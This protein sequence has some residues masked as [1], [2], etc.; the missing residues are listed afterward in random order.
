MQLVIA[1]KP[2][3]G[4]SIAK[5]LKANEKKDGYVQ[6]NGF[7]VSW[8]IGHLVTLANAEDYDPSYKI[9]KRDDLP[10][11]PKEWKYVV[12]NQTHK[13]F[14][15][16]EEL[17]HRSNIS[18]VICAT[19]AGREGELIFRLVY[20]QAKCSKP[21][22]RLWLS[23][24]EDKAIMKAFTDLRPGKDFDNLYEAAQCRQKADWIVGISGTRLFSSVYGRNLPVGRVMTPTLAIIQE[25]TD[26]IENF[27]VEKFFT[28]I[29]NTGFESV[30]RRMQSLEE[31]EKV[32]SKCQG[33]SAT[34][35]EMIA[36]EKKSMP[37]KLFDLTTLQRVCNRYFGYT[38]QQV[39][40]TAQQLYEKK[41][42]TY[43]RTD[44]CYVSEDTVPTVIGVLNRIKNLNLTE[45]PS[46][47]FDGSYQDNIIRFV[48]GS[49]VSDH[50]ALLPTEQIEK[51]TMSQLTEKEQ[52][53][54]MCVI[55]RLLC[56]VSP[57]EIHIERR[58]TLECEGEVFVAKG[59][60]TKNEGWKS[61][62]RAYQNSIGKGR[63]NNED[64]DDGFA[65]ELPDLEKGTKLSQMKRPDIKAGET[66]PP[67]PFTE[68]TL[69]SAM[70]NASAKDFAAIEGV[71]RTGLGTPATRAGVIEKLVKLEFITRK[72]K[73]LLITQKGRSLISIVPDQI[74]SAELTVG[75]EKI[76]KEIEKGEVSPDIFM[77]AIS[78]SMRSIVSNYRK[79]DL[80]ESAFESKEIIGSCPR[81][82]S[83]VIVHQKGFFCRNADCAFKL[84][85]NDMF[86]SSRKKEITKTMAVSFLKNRK[87]IVK[88]L[89]SEKKGKEYDAV[90]LM[91]DDGGDRVHFR[92]SFDDPMLK[93]LKMIDAKRKK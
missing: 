40:D 32:Q 48:D 28:V 10:I 22:R 50:H 25:R 65:Q 87:A 7:I 74:K 72:G 17:M 13:Q 70:E 66:T 63:K 42:L 27:N 11:I 36:D 92:L 4:I 69:L 41:L 49:K 52:N 61:V 80:S 53:V 60:T 88:G 43:P 67:K 26:A 54:L 78:L 20:M 31:A 71:E 83:P 91:E 14:D 64:K 38:A 2:S 47:Y 57:E 82:G 37:P 75:W 59:K 68:D 34:V 79:L 12:I 39:L 51:N 24:M 3:V 16:L 76:L 90:V 55:V 9:W 77:E 58:I 85:K 23:S 62:E 5:V 35:V 18:E 19:D 1:E 56:A 8:C 15:I 73:Q 93:T 6:G 29:L 44:S 86:F 21:V 45:V 30:S 81:C 89:W 33:K 46:S 84:W